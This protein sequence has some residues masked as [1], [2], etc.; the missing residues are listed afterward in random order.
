M[1][2]A[3]VV[4]LVVVLIGCGGVIFQANSSPG[5]AV[6]VSGFVTFV[7]FTVILNGSGTL[8][9]VTVVTLQ[10]TGVFQTFTFCG[11]Q[12]S[13]FPLNQNMQVNFVPAPTCGNIV[14]VFHL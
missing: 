6:T 12:S 9:N 3:L 13:M 2:R 11:S 1:T 10:Q 4:L 7:Q 5:N 8:V 14:A